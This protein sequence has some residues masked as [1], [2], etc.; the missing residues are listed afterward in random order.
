[1]LSNF[2][3]VLEVPLMDPNLKIAYIAMIKFI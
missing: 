2:Y 1:M 3:N